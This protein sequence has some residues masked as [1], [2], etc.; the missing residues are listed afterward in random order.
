MDDFIKFYE[1]NKNNYSFN[2]Q[3]D[4]NYNDLS[5]FI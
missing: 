4:F 1:N 2:V 5:N 3:T